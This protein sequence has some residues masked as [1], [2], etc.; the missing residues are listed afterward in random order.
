[1]EE[2]FN[3]NFVVITKDDVKIEE[4]FDLLDNGYL[5]G[6]MSDEAILY[7]E[8]DERGICTNYSE[9]DGKSFI[10]KEYSHEEIKK[11]YRSNEVK[12]LVAF[13]FTENVELI[14]KEDDKMYYICRDLAAIRC[15]FCTDEEC[16]CN[17]RYLYEYEK[18]VE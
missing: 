14:T 3:G 9:P 18:M 15:I 16:E 13:F 11:L 7:I 1:M 6:Y 8:Q 4:I 12:F 10:K 5:I 17:R 2:I